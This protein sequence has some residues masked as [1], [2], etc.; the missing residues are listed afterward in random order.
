MSEEKTKKPIFKKW[1]FWLLIVVGL[2]VVIAIASSGGSGSSKE[3][4][5][6]ADG[7]VVTTVRTTKAPKADD[8]GYE[9]IYNEYMDKVREAA[10][11]SSADALAAMAS[12]GVDKMAQYQLKNP[13]TM[14]DYMEWSQKLLSDAIDIGVSALMDGDLDDILAGLE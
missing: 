8:K 4:V 10:P 5:T 3:P 9:E 2:I 6:D 11:N 12:E 14:D 7:N 13:G 1:W